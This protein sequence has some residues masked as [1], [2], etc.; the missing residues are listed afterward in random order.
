VTLEVWIGKAIN[1]LIALFAFVIAIYV[2]RRIMRIKLKKLGGYHKLANIFYSIAFIIFGLSLL[3]IS[4]VLPLIISFAA[5]LGIVGVIFGFSIMTV[6]L[7]N[8]VA[9]VALIFDKLIE[10]GSRI[11]INGSEGR[12]MQ[13]SLTSTKLVTDDG[14]LLI[15]PNKSFRERPYLIIKLPRGEG[16]RAGQRR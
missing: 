12:I 7:S 6:W 1:T 2:I 3:H 4:G 10:V 13:I 9:G 11:K 5:A 8:A 15:I 14:K 16:Q